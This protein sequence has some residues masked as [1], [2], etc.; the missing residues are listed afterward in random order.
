MND[1]KP[2]YQAMLDGCK[3]TKPIKLALF[4]EHGA[5]ALG[6]AMVGSMLPE[7]AFQ[8][9]YAWLYADHSPNPLLRCPEAKCWMLFHRHVDVITHLNDHHGLPR[10][11][12]ALD[13]LKP[14]EE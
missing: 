5:C 1:R 2:A 6:A 13:Y 8:T 9:H 3:V 10:E 14:L 4:G 12:I 7:S 11:R